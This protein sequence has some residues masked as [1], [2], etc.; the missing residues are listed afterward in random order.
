[1]STRAAIAKEIFAK[2]S[3]LVRNL[4]TADKTKVAAVAKRLGLDGAKATAQQII[5]SARNNKLMT[6]IVLYELYGL[7]DPVL[8]ELLDGEPELRRT[9]ELMGMTADAVADTTSVSDIIAFEDEFRVIENAAR[10]VGG[11][12]NLLTLRNAI[13]LDNSHYALYQQFSNM[14]RNVLR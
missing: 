9:I 14:A 5:A 12:N 6:A 8:Q 3:G 2:A 10:R 11:L 7:A 4:S 13:M 1:M